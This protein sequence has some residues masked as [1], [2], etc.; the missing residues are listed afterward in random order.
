MQSF[1]DA[2]TPEEWC[3]KLQ[4]TGAAISARALRTKAREHGQFYSLGRAMLLSSDHV[5]CLLKI[6]AAGSQQGGA[7]R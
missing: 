3:K 6:D 5:E 1:E 7:G 4:K 2:L